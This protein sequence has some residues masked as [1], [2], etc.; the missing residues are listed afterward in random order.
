MTNETKIQELEAKI[1]ELTSRFESVIS[2]HQADELS[3]GDGEATEDV[4]AAEATR[5]SSRRNG[6]L[7]LLGRR[8]RSRRRRR[9][10]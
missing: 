1:A 5:T 9:Q 8:Q 6:Y 7:R 10:P 4:S 3:T 2:S